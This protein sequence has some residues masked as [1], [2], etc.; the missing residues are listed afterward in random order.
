MNGDGVGGIGTAVGDRSGIAAS[1]NYLGNL[2]R[3]ERDFGAARR[4]FEE[5]LTLS[6]EL[7]NKE[8]ITSN[9][10]N[11][12]AIA[13]AFRDFSASRDFF[14]EGLEIAREIGNKT[15]VACALDG[16]AAIASLTENKKQAAQLAGAAEGLRENIGYEIELAERHF[17]DEYVT[18]IRTALDGN[19]FTAAYQKGQT[20][21]L[22]EAVALAEILFSEQNEQT[23]EVIVEKHKIKRIVVE[24][25]I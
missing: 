23:F 6:R 14:A 4:L 15:A 7:G 19:S 25:E 3:T 1:L 22:N 13:F 17:C 11:L 16:F 21:S 5:A 20:F 8:A 9:L 10:N 24:E 12:G 18:I 2:T